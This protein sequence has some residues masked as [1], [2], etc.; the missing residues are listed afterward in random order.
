MKKLAAVILSLCLGV[1]AL[2]GCQSKPSQAAGNGAEGQTKT[3]ENSQEGK[4]NQA[5]ENAREG[6]DN[7]AGEDSQS[8]EAAAQSGDTITI[9]DHSGA[10]VEIPKEVNRVVVT[11][12][13]PLPSIITVFLGSGEKIVGM[14]P[15]SMSA[16]KTGLLGELFPDILNA[17]TD[18]MNGSDINMEELMNLKPDVVFYNAG[19]KEL[20]ESLRSAGFAAVAVSVNK[21]DYDSIE[22]YDQWVGLLSQIFPEKEDTAERVS[23]YSQKV[24]ED[25]QSRV[26]GLKDEERRNILFLFNYSDTTMITSGKKFF[27]QFWCDAV[28]GRNVAEGVAAENSNAVINMEQV[29]QW[30]PDVI[31]ITNFTPVQ[32]EDLYE[33]A[34]G[35]DDWSPVKAVQDKNVY[36]LPLGTYRSYTPSTDTPMTLLWMAKEVYPDLFADV[37]L[38]KEV[39]D[40]YKT[41]YGVELSDEQVQRMYHPG[42]DAAAGFKK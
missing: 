18:F 35:Q 16:A 8:G 15:A 13:L 12:I 14:N 30:N 40:Y 33:N 37:D 31:F 20:G 19:S 4:N 28:G 41:M 39:R 23:Q 3:A 27:G 5:V 22:T 32:P 24:Y 36:K 42:R 2:A 10:Q 21:W 1:S 17:S 9:T 38:T 26:S 29:Y 11:D 6:K 7:Q 25:I 34:V